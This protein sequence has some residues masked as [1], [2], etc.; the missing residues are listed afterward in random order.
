MCRIVEFPFSVDLH[1]R[2]LLVVPSELNIIH[3]NICKYPRCVGAILYFLTWPLARLLLLTVSVAK[4]ISFL[5]PG[6]Y[7]QCTAFSH[8]RVF[9]EGTL[10]FPIHGRDCENPEQHSFPSCCFDELSHWHDPSGAQ[11]TLPVAQGFHGKTAELSGSNRW[12]ECVFSGFRGPSKEGVV[13]V[14]TFSASENSVKLSCS[15]EILPCV[16]ALVRNTLSGPAVEPCALTCR[17]L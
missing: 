11:R 5:P 6:R 10:I 9:R 15:R 1:S 12:P 16:C 4:A 2:S 7:S 17:I 8:P 13:I 14:A 3:P